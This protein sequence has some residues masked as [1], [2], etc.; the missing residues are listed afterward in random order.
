MKTKFE[1]PTR[2]QVTPVHQVIYDSLQNALG[3]VPNLYAIFAHSN[4]ALNTFVHA[5]SAKSSL[6]GQEKEVVNLVVSQVNDCDYCLA[7]HTLLA[8]KNNL[9]GDQILE[10]R[11]GSASFDAKLDALVKLAKDIT[12]NKGHANSSAVDNF[13]AAGY[14]KGHL[15]DLILLVGIR[16]ITNYVYAVSNV[17]IDWPLAPTLDRCTRCL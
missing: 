11:T 1:I 13:L 16:T 5:Q 10:I 17:E 7:A 4:T 3:F 9:T 2:E 15:I 12:V 14:N 6:T 8:G